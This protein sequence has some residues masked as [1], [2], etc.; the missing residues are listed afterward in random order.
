MLFDLFEYIDQHLNHSCLEEQ[1][2]DQFDNEQHRYFLEYFGEYQL[3]TACFVLTKTRQN[4][5]HKS[6][7]INEY[8]IHLK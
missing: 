1:S 7:H 3:K 2:I 4:Q 5:K 6:N 8:Q